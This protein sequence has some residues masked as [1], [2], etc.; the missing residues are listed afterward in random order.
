MSRRR[1]LIQM[2]GKP[3]IY[4]TRTFDGVQ[5][6]YQGKLVFRDDNEKVYQFELEIGKTYIIAQKS[7]T[8]GYC[9]TR[10]WSNA[11]LDIGGQTYKD[12]LI[13]VGCSTALGGMSFNDFPNVKR[14]FVAKAKYLYAYNSVVTTAFGDDEIY[15]DEMEA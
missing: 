4:A 3:H 8:K 1:T 15:L 9:R 11:G 6:N 13:T 12:D 2:M 10:G 7:D 14:T 5:L